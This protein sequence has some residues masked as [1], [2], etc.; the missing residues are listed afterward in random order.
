MKDMEHQ[1]IEGTWEEISRHAAELSGK[2]VRVT[3]LEEAEPL[4]PN[5]AMLEALRKVGERA[6]Q[7]PYSGPTEESLKMLREGRAGK[8]F[9]YGDS[10]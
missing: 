1:V 4:S 8:M 7:M 10:E 3:V 9:G 2:R 6:E 5:E